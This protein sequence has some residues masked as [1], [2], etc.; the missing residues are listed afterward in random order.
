MT[1]SVFLFPHLKIDTF[2]KIWCAL[3]LFTKSNFTD[4]IPSNIKI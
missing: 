3:P 1:K 2:T 4:F